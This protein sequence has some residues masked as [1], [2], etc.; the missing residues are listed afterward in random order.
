ML[1]E[2]RARRNGA[3][4]ALLSYAR[5]KGGVC[6]YAY[7]PALAEKLHD[8]KVFALINL[9]IQRRFTSGHALALYENCYRFERTGSTGWWPIDLFRR[10]MGVDGLRLLRD[11]QAS[12]RQDHQAGGGRGEH[13][14]RTSW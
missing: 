8:P 3:C 6:E 1:D 12:E 13:D 2:R 10:L 5:L 11:L 14:R 4:R 7:S 9:N